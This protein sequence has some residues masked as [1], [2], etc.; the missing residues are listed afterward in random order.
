MKKRSASK[1]SQ[2]PKWY[3]EFIACILDQLPRPEQLLDQNTALEWINNQQ[4]LKRLLIQILL[5]PFEVKEEFEFAEYGNQA[6][7][8]FPSWYVKFQSSIVRQLPRP[9]LLDQNLDQ[10]TAMDWIKNQESL[11]K[12]LEALVHPDLRKFEFA[13]AFNLTVPKQYEHHIQIT[14]FNQKNGL[15]GCKNLGGDDDTYENVTEK[16]EPGKTYLVKFFKNNKRASLT[17]CLDF[18]KKQKAI[19]VG[20]QGLTLTWELLSKFFPYGETASFDKK[21]ALYSSHYVPIIWRE[22]NGEWGFATNDFESKHS[23]HFICFCETA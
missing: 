23:S 9:G 20:A 7:A 12:A 18:L 3:V 11:K 6:P 15:V 14:S 13:Y 2:F 1:T 4:T 5:P 8:S 17:E 16:L 22:K 21:E 19:L 10:K